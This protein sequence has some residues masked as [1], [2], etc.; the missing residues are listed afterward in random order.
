MVLLALRRTAL[1]DDPAVQAA[2]RRGVDWLLA[3]QNR[4]GGWAAFDV[5][6]DNRS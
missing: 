1:A 6:I 5:D 3:M 4:D 2:T